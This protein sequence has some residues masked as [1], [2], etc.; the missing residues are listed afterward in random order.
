M[1]T[2][3]TAFTAITFAGLA[4]LGGCWGT[5]SDT[6]PIHL[7]QNMDHQEK[8]EAQEHN[9]F[10]ADGRFMR[11]PPE[12]TV[13]VGHLRND[14]HLYR[15][16]DENGKLADVLPPSIELNEE[17]LARGRERYDIYCSPCHGVTGRGNGIATRRGGGMQPPPVNLH[18]PGLQPVPL[19]YFFNVMTRGKGKMLS[20]AAQI[21]VEDRWKIAA[22]VRVLQVSHRGRPQL[23]DA[24]GL[25]ER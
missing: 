7:Q 9:G 2:Q 13:A 11:L 24:G 25:N 18:E 17:T 5:P 20:Y 22:W 14:D 12:G 16:L 6:P 15:G 3:R 8:G 10:F 19:G 1:S 4:M 23:A 21:S